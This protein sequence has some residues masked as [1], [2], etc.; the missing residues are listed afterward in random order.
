M[1]L[2]QN[3]RIARPDD[4]SCTTSPARR[5]LSAGR[6][7]AR[8]GAVPRQGQRPVDRAQ[9]HRSSGRAS[10]GRRS[11]RPAT[12]TAARRRRARA[13]TPRTRR[14]TNLGPTNKKLIDAVDR[15]RRRRRRRRIPEPRR[16]RS[17][18]ST[19]VG[20]G[21]RSAHL[22]RQRRCSRCRASRGSAAQ[23]GR[24]PRRSSTAH[25]E[26]RQW[27]FLGEPRVNVLLLNL[28]STSAGR[29]VIGEAVADPRLGQD[30]AAAW[31]DRAS[32]L[33]RS[34]LTSTRRCSG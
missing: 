6:H 10:S 33:R 18:W 17:I 2:T 16:S 34:A 24:D 1:N 12:S 23:R 9:R 32:S 28:A 31:R 8:A 29:S 19:D 27:G 21:P 3:L 11:R 22:A 7:R 15:R 25:T 30:V 5:R 13:T 20:V 26:G 14:G 4:R